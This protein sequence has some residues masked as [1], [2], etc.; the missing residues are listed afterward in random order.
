MKKFSLH[1]FAIHL[2]CTFGYLGVFAQNTAAIVLDSVSK[3]AFAGKIWMHWQFDRDKYKAANGLS[4][5]VQRRTLL[6]PTTGKFGKPIAKEGWKNV[7]HKHNFVLIDDHDL[8]VRTWYAYQVKALWQGAESKWSNEEYGFLKELGKIGTAI[9]YEPQKKQELAW[10]TVQG[11][12]HY[13]LQIIEQVQGQPYNHDP[14]KGFQK[15]PILKEVVLTEPFYTW[16]GQQ[17]AILWSVQAIN[18]LDSGYFPHPLHADSMLRYGR[19][20][21]RD[22][23]L[24][25]A[26]LNQATVSFLIQNRTPKILMDLNVGIFLSNQADFNSKEAVLAKSIPIYLPIQKRIGFE[27]AIQTTGY[28]Y[29]HLVPVQSGVILSAEIETIPIR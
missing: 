24:K 1:L 4:F 9:L 28:Q 26:S 16:T 19:S 22:S 20:W 14:E 18:G 12:T 5:E 25:W 23:L 6:N 3:G 7:G 11:A 29:I 15:V 13:R 2:L 8:K 10:S 17:K 21:Q 27:E